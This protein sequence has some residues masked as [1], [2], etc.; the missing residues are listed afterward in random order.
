MDLRAGYVCVYPLEDTE[1]VGD[2]RLP[3]RCVCCCVSAGC[4]ICMYV[5]LD[6]GRMGMGCD[7]MVHLVTLETGARQHHRE[8]RQRGGGRGWRDV[9]PKPRAKS[10]N[11]TRR[12]SKVSCVMPIS[13]CCLFLSGFGLNLTF[14]ARRLEPFWCRRLRRQRT[15]TE[16]V[17]QTVGR[18]SDGGWL[19]VSQRE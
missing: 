19:S 2:Q 18:D 1:Y 13:F 15:Q 3:W 12:N 5:L 6:S 10:T 7:R 14:V 16:G 8:M 17:T 4:R 9:S 11:T